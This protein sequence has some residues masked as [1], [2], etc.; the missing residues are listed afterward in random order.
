MPR[1]SMSRRRGRSKEVQRTLSLPAGTVLFDVN[2]PSRTMQRLD[3]GRVRLL[4][5][6]KATVE[7]LEAGDFFGEACLFRSCCGNQTAQAL[8]PVEIAVFKKPDL[9]KRLRQ[10]RV[11]TSA[12]LRNLARRIQRCQN[13]VYEFVTEPAERRLAFLLMRL[14][15]GRRASEWVRLPFPITNG[16][17]AKSIGTTRGRIS[18]FLNRFERLGFLRR[19]EGNADQC[20]TCRAIP[21]VGNRTRRSGVGRDPQPA[22]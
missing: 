17:L 16:D 11:F 9:L 15:P 10:D 5:E 22:N 7:Y 13:T 20:A 3:A 1:A 21:K 19:R 6:S 12:L 8:T 2:S 18:Y 4:A 14:S